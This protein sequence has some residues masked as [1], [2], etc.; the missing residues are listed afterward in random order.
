MAAL[1]TRQCTV[2]PAD[3]DPVSVTYREGGDGPP[4]VLLH[5]IG[6]DAG[7]VSWAKVLP[8]LAEEYTVY[9][10]DL[11]GHG[12]SERPDAD[13][14]TAY[15]EAVLDSLLGEL[16][17]RSPR[18]VGVSMGGSV[19]LSH[20]LNGGDPD[21]LVL[22]NSYGLGSDAYWRAPASVLLRTPGIGGSLWGSVA[23]TRSGL[24]QVLD[25]MTAGSGVDPDLVEDVYEHTS[26]RGALRAMRRW[27]RNEFGLGGFRTDD[28]ARLGS[29]GVPT[30][31]VHGEHDPLVPP[32]WSRE[33]A[34]QLP[35]GRLAV[36]PETG[37]WL[38][39]ERPDRFL[40]ILRPFLG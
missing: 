8:A 33:A 16:D 12:G 6:L 29:L 32:R 14:S 10:P 22:V 3:H 40:S 5:G 1:Q 37:H 20:A 15:Y 19:A 17:V 27:Q 34:E 21:R 30:L 18:L 38:P 39:R 25:L 31:L 13:Y 26:D 24:R 23:R 28:S 36:L 2:E 7:T 35:D 4:V 9:A 11:P